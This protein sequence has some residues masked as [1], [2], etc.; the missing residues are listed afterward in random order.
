MFFLA[1]GGELVQAYGTKNLI[2]GML[3][4]TLFIG[5]IGYFLARVSSETG[6]DTDLLTISSGFGYKGAGITSLIYVFNF[7]MF[8]ALEGS[9]MSDAVHAQFHEIPLWFLY[10][11]FGILFIPLTWYGLTIMNYIMWATIPIYFILLFWT[12]IVANNTSRNIDF[13]LYNP[14][15]P[16]NT[17]PGLDLLQTLS[18]V[19]ALV[20]NA[21]V[22][23]DIGRFIPKKQ[24]NVATFAIGYIFEAITF[25]GVTL[26]GA[27]LALKLNQSN[28][29]VY[30][31]A[32]LGIWGVVFV[33][34]TQI[35]INVLNTY[36][37]SLAFAN[38]FSRI[39]NFAPG[40]HWWVILT[41]VLSII[42]MFAGILAH[43]NKFLIFEAVFIMAW[44]MA[45]LSDIVLNKHLLKLSPLKFEYKKEKV[46]NYNPVGLSALVAALILSVPMAFGVFGSLGQALVGQLANRW[47]LGVN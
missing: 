22:G 11:L 14:I 23:G 10:I 46:Y 17:L 18:A 37:G 8:S 12:I 30:I 13:W 26:L 28:P 47:R 6:L 45:V 29:G 21:T 31:P 44:I 25:L 1:W 15:H 35:R 40:R 24:R 32:L 7:L 2:I 38:F 42:F 4:G 9:I 39:F 19:L 3:F 43:I 5:T 36:F 41:A 33:L 27:W 34:I 20:V 16:V